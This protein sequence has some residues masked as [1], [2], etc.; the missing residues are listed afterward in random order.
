VTFDGGPA[1][2]EL[3]TSDLLWTYSPLQP[4]KRVYLSP[5]QLFTSGD[6]VQVTT[7]LGSCVAV[8]LFDSEAEVGG[9]NHFLLPQGAPPS[10]RFADHA[11]TLL[12]RGVLALGAERGHL[13]AKLFGGACVLEAL[14]TSSALGARNVEVARERLC[15]EGIPVVAEDTGGD[16]GRKLIVEVRT[17][18]AW[19]RA[20]DANCRQ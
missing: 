7:I 10:P 15:A 13:R 1:R 20:I 12:L 4:A 9:V 18:S 5:G 6:H 8:C 17:G 19:V 14:R 2:G 11:T 16:L 3:G